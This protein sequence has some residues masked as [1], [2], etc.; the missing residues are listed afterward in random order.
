MVA[1]S[2]SA[3]SGVEECLYCCS[4]TPRQQNPSGL[5][6][7]LNPLY[8]FLIEYFVFTQLMKIKVMKFRFH[9][10]LENLWTAGGL[11]ASDRGL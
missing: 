9:Q 8:K 10:D 6:R 2:T 3:S 4:S 11:S 5:R 1:P 7:T